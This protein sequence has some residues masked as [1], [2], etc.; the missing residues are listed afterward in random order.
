[1]KRI[2]DDFKD[3]AIPCKIS[4]LKKVFFVL[5]LL[6]FVFV[7]LMYKES[8]LGINLKDIIT[9]D[10]GEAVY[11]FPHLYGWHKGIPKMEKS[12]VEANYHTP[13]AG[14][15][16]QDSKTEE[17]CVLAVVL[18]LLPIKLEVCASIILIFVQNLKWIVKYWIK[19]QHN[20]IDEYWT[21]EWKILRINRRLADNSWRWLVM[22]C[23]YTIVRVLFT[24][25]PL[26]NRERSSTRFLIL[27]I[28]IFIF[29]CVTLI[30][31]Q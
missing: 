31:I 13:L 23:S 25:T 26:L 6:I 11:H 1:M 15:E 30:S 8:S 12:L 19:T 2:I 18:H 27:F 17:R 7:F 28:F 21:K 10:Y 4:G 29:R 14:L 22:P 24:F 20:N 16:F 3:F 5:F 9:F